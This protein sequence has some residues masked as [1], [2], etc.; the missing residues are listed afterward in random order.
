MNI[1]EE[2]R[3]VNNKLFREYSYN[4]EDRKYLYELINYNYDLISY[5][6][7]KFFKE[8]KYNKE[9]YEVALASM[10]HAIENYEMDKMSGFEE[11]LVANIKLE[12][13]QFNLKIKPIFICNSDK[14]N[15]NMGDIW[16]N[17][18]H[19]LIETLGTK[20]MRD[21]LVDKEYRKTVSNEIKNKIK[22]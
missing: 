19:N 6:I 11:Y 13:E 2:K 9:V 3:E 12:I 8:L 17:K 5:T 7:F 10:I 15:L 20:K 21:G 4:R 22:N 14:T 1:F 18:N 16:Y